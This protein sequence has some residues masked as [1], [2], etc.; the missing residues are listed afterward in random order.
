M[1]SRSNDLLGADL[2]VKSSTELPAQWQ[3]QAQDLG[4]AT[5]R[6]LTF[7]S[8]AL[9]GD[10]ISLVAIKAVDEGYPLRGRLATVTQGYDQETA[11]VDLA[12]VQAQGPAQGQAWV[13]P[14]LLAL[15]NADVGDVLEVGEIQLTIAAVIIEESDR[16][17]NFYT[18]SPRLM[19]HW[20]DIPAAGLIGPG[21]RVNYRLLLQGEPEALAQFRDAT[22]LAPTQNY[23]SLNDSN[24]AM[25]DS[26]ERARQ[27]LGLSALLAVI[28][29]SVAVA[30]A[31]RR[32][33]E[34][35]FDISALM[36][37]F[38]LTRSDVWR[39]YSSQLVMLALIGTALGLLLAFGIQNV[40]LSVLAEV[41]P[42]NL[43]QAPLSAWLL[44]ASSGALSLLGFAL[45]YLLPL[46]QVSP[47]RVL[48]RDMNPVPLKGWLLTALAVAALT[49]LLW[50]FTGDIV[51]SVGA[52]LAGSL[53]LLVLMAL[54]MG[55]MARLRTISLARLPLPLRFAWQHLSRDRRQTAGQVLALSLTLMVMLVVA[56]V[57]NEL[58]ADWQ[59]SLPDNAPNVFAINIQGYEQQAF[60]DALTA[61]DYPRQNMYPMVPGRLLKINDQTIQ[62]LGL[63]TDRALN[64]DL[65]LTSDPQLPETNR[66]VA[67]SWDLINDQTGQ[68]SVEEDL[69]KRLGVNLG[70]QLTFLAAGVEFDATVSSIREVDWGSLTPN[71]Y[72][73]LS[74][75]LL[76][77]LPASYMTSFH[78]PPAQQ[79]AMTGLIRQFPSVTLLDMQVVLGQIQT[80]LEQVSLA[81]ELILSFVLIAAFLVLVAALMA[82]LPERLREG[83]VLRTLG[84]QTPLIRRAQWLEFLLLG[85]AASMLALLGSEAAVYGLYT[86][87]FD[88]PYQSLGWMW[89]ALP[90]VTVL[91]VM[92]LGLWLLRRAVTVSP[93]VVLR[94]LH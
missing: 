23:E 46:S 73:M 76:E 51:I 41:L 29:A 32:Y 57:R 85:G 74:P 72:M 56:V 50:F 82:S 92:L 28:L 81:L 67:G 2:R 86:Q 44:G 49:L 33:A 7:P 61:A 64:R 22:E 91:T 20:Q 39:I 45:P 16:G 17:G 27:Y 53:I 10:E 89:L 25:A 38:G 84:A 5:A 4:L 47:L 40:L 83:A 55:L 14:R 18:L 90:P 78:V 65:A 24:Q 8:V 13:E 63:D 79:Q 59:A 52:M 36:R 9:Y 12:Q 43:P 93:L 71:F 87:V 60:D 21:S 77:A 15:L 35:H 30:I 6:T 42:E 37:T 26:I 34:R 58:L 19:M 94:Q 69:A 70:D 11:L 62:A 3:T 1:A 54:L 66:I 48:R 68:V 75:E 80:L 31:A 88:M